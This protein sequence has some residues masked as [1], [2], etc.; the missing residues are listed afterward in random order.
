MEDSKEDP[1]SA[2]SQERQHK[3]D[4]VVVLGAVMEF[5]DKTKSWG[6]PTIIEKYPGKLVEGKARALAAREVQNLAPFILVTGGSD[7]NPETGQQDSRA[8]ELANLI[9]DRYNVPGEKVIPIGEVSGSSTIGNVSDLVDYLK[10]HPEIIKSGK[11]AILSPKFQKERAEIMFDQN[12]FFAQQN[13]E[14]EWLIV[15]DILE[16]RHPLYKR[17]AGK[18]YGTPAA[19]INRRMEQKGVATLKAEQNKT[20]KGEN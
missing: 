5:N 10:S 9:T 11:I 20:L 6:F 17:W 1:T 14:L 2:E 18:V 4:A 12:P 7:I 15:E 13:I 3:Y 19:K 16:A 8:A